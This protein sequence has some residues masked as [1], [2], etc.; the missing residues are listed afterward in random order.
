MKKTNIGMCTGHYNYNRHTP[1]SPSNPHFHSQSYLH[2]E[3]IRLCTNYRIKCSRGIL[4]ITFTNVIVTITNILVTVVRVAL[5]LPSV[6]LTRST[7]CSE[8]HFLG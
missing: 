2:Y 5:L 6:S 8:F 4:S 7:L 1:T 3:Y